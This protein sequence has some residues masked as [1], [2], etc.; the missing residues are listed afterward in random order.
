[1][2]FTL[3]QNLKIFLVHAGD[4]FTLAVGHNNIHKYSSHFGFESGK[5]RIG[6]RVLR[7]QPRCKQEKRKKH[8]QVTAKTHA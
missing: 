3:L 7:G 2:F 4:W 8:E 6:K 5:V 1:L